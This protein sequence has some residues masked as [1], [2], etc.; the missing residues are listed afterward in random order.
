MRPAD[1]IQRVHC[2]IFGHRLVVRLVRRR[3]GPGFNIVPDGAC[4]RCGLP[5]EV[6]LELGPG[7]TADPS[8]SSHAP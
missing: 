5:L 3:D 8:P 6:E 1:V 7:I 2:L 4:S